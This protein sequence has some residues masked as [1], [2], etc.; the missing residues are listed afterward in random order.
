MENYWQIYQQLEQIPAAVPQ[1]Q[2]TASPIV[3]Q[4]IKIWRSLLD[5]DA[6][7]LT[8]IQQI[9]RLERCYESDLVVRRPSGWQRLWTVL[10]QPLLSLRFSQCQEPQVWKTID[11]VGRVWWHVFD[12]NTGRTASLDSE[13]EVQIWLEERYP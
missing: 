2:T 12:P 4:V 11:S 7:Q 8:Q 5:K 10:N 3:K 9:Q 13:E 6:A 1:Q